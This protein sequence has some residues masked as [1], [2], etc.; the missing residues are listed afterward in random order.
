M[1]RSMLAHASTDLI[2]NRNTDIHKDMDVFVKI[3]D[4]KRI[5]Q[6][7]LGTYYRTQCSFELVLTGVMNG[8]SPI[9]DIQAV[10]NVCGQLQGMR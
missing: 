5:C 6:E 3:K 1:H 4:D 7:G 2:S 9:H 10:I 8:E